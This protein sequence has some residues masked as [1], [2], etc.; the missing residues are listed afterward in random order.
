MQFIAGMLGSMGVQG[1]VQVM[2]TAIP[3]DIQGAVPGLPHAA[4]SSDMLLMSYGLVV[5]AAQTSRI[6]FSG[7]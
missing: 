5:C 6:C 4:G 2:H 7:S 3:M 1:A